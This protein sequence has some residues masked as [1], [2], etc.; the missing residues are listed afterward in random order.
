MSSLFDPECMHCVACFVRSCENGGCGD[1][2]SETLNVVNSTASTNTVCTVLP[3]KGCLLTAGLYVGVNFIRHCADFYE[4]GAVDLHLAFLMLAYS[5]FKVSSP[6]VLQV[7]SLVK[8][9]I[10]IVEISLL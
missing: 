8:L 9:D 2:L 5:R 1:T 7:T 3:V 10:H 6:L 4:G